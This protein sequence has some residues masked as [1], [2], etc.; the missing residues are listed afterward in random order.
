MLV[1]INKLRSDLKNDLYA[2]FF[3][4]DCG[5]AIVESFEIDKM[6]DEEL[7]NF[8]IKN[9]VNLSKYSENYY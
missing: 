1:D 7:I 3:A 4:T 9:N 8:A 6:S 2:A 5:G